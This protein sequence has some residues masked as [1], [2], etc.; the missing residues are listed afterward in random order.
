M[1]RVATQSEFSGSLDFVRILKTSQDIHDKLV[2]FAQSHDKVRILL[3]CWKFLLWHCLLVVMKWKGL[4]SIFLKSCWLVSWITEWF[5]RMITQWILDLYLI[6]RF[7][8]WKRLTLNLVKL[9]LVIT[10]MNGPWDQFLHATLLYCVL[11]GW[12]SLLHVNLLT[13]SEE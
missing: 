1:S 11:V 12:F 13:F 5:W 7:Y 3:N 2:I 8:L 9:S 10:W 6:W 4:V